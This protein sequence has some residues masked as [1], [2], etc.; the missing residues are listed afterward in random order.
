MD[1]KIE[2]IFIAALLLQHTHKTIHTPTPNSKDRM[3]LQ[4]M[5]DYAAKI[6]AERNARLKKYLNAKSK[7][8]IN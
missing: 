4:I 7:N 5:Y 1:T 3:A 6:R 8:Q 2:Y